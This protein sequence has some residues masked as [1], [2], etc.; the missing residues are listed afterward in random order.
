MKAITFLTILSL[1]ALNINAQDH[2]DRVW[3]AGYNEYPGIQGYGQ[4]KLRFVGD[5]I[6]TETLDLNMNFESTMAV[7][8]DE[9][10]NVLFYT[11]GCNVN[12]AERQPMSNG[13]GLNPGNISDMVCPWKG[14]ISPRGATA[15]PAPGFSHLYY[16]IHMGVRYD[17]IKRINYGPVYY[18]LVDMS[19]DGGKGVIVSKNNILA[20]GLLEPYDIV[21][22]GNGRDWWIL[23]PEYETNHYRTFLLSPEGIEEQSYQEV[24]SV[25]ACKRIGSTAFS[26]NGNRYVRYQ[27]CRAEVFDF[28]RCSGQLS[29]YRTIDPPEHL[30]GGGGVAFSPNGG[31][32]FFTSQFIFWQTDL[33][34]VPAVPDTAL[35]LDYD[36]GTVPHLMQYGANGRIYL[37]EINRANYFSAVRNPGA[38]PGQDVGFKFADVLLP[39]ASVRTLPH[40]PN[41]RLYDLPDSPC[42]TLGISVSAESPSSKS[43]D[44]IRINPNPAQDIAQIQFPDSPLESIHVFDAAGRLV[45]EINIQKGSTHVTL[46]LSTYVPGIYFLRIRTA[47]GEVV[48]RALAVVR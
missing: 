28:D 45:Q 25:L 8:A 22:H 1:I 20:D 42:D 35:M 2:L 32:L 38:M 23:V 24:G 44:E 47:T 36:W 13:I 10:G 6:L 43:F 41:Y 39:V 26:P 3:L 12:N 11:N 5:T 40:F 18:S 4:V 21:R 48:T 33:S 37:N 7:V 30:W 31:S 19:Q 34:H 15:L 9:Q 17:T 14:Y 27:N 29:H 46:D 16:L